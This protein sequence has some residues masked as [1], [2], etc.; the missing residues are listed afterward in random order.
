MVHVPRKQV[1]VD[2][3]A[4]LPRDQRERLGRSE[5]RLIEYLDQQFQ[6]DG[7]LST[8]NSTTSQ[9][10]PIEPKRPRTG[11]RCMGGDR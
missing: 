8:P 2:A 11:S 6:R 9:A 5:T 7:K 10:A 1:L 3:L 4:S